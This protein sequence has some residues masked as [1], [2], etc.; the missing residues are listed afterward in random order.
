MG[1]LFTKDGVDYG[2]KG[3]APAGQ[4]I[5]D[6]VKTLAVGYPFNMT[7]TSARDGKH[8][9][10]NDP[11][12]RGEALDLRSKHLTPDEKKRVLTDIQTILYKA[13]RRFYAFLED[14]GGIGE[15]FHCQLRNGFANVDKTFLKDWA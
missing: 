6:T 10:P 5:Y 8:S 1:Q 15:H 3:L 11:H 14:E 2:P 4:L 12:Y 9:G 13:P 7:V